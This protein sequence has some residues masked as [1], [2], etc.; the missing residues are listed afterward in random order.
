MRRAQACVVQ[1]HQPDIGRH[2]G[3]IAEIAKHILSG[4]QHRMRDRLDRAIAR[5]VSPEIDDA[6]LGEIDLAGLAVRPQE[7]ARVIAAGDGDGVEAYRLE[8]AQGLV[9]AA[10]SEIPGIGV[11]GLVAHDAFVARCAWGQAP[12]QSSLR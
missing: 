12:N 9:H 4:R 6:V 7:L 10:F 2:R 3:A 1:Q 5:G 11:D 8:L